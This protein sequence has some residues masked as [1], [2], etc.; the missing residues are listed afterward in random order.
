MR[1]A[2]LAAAHG[3]SD[4]S[5]RIRDFKTFAGVTLVQYV[6]RRREIFGPELAPGR[7]AIFLPSH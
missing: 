2:D 5:H 3:W 4:Q 6:S 1:W 7:D